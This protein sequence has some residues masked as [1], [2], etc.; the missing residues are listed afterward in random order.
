[1][2]IELF[3]IIIDGAG[4]IGGPTLSADLDAAFRLVGFRSV[5]LNDRYHF[6][7][8]RFFACRY[9][10]TV[11]HFCAHAFCCSSP[12]TGGKITKKPPENSGGLDF[13]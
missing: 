6:F 1:M 2:G 4:I 10:K 7:R 9:R 8:T 3:D 11:K 13:V 5:I 12:M